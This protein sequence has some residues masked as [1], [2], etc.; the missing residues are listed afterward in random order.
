MFDTRSANGVYVQHQRIRGPVALNDGDHI[1]ICNHEF[2][3]K[4]QPR[5]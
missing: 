3:F 5:G 2:T 4:I 1:R